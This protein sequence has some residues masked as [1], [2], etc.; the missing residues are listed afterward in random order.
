[1]YKLSTTLLFLFSSLLLIPSAFAQNE[2]AAARPPNEFNRCWGLNFMWQKDFTVG[3]QIIDRLNY[4][5]ST[6]DDEKVT[7]FGVDW[8]LSPKASISLL[9][10]VGIGNDKAENTSG[11]QEFSATEIGIKASYN[12]YL[13]SM[14]K[15]VYASL[16]PWVSYISYSETQTNTPATGT[17][18]KDEYSA[19]KL[20]IG[21]NASAY[22]RPWENLNWEFYAGYNLGVFITPESTTTQTFNGQTTETSGPSSF[23]FQDCGGYLGTRFYFESQAQY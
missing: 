17:E 18:T 5:L 1:M 6:Q 14:N 9:G 23:H 15:P 8:Y 12:Y 10:S 11:T 22:V 21:I 20:G 13:Y 2:T 7:G 4:D 19:S 3:K 16:A